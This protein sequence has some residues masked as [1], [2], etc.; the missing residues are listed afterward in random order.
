MCLCH[1]QVLLE[2]WQRIMILSANASIS[3][4]N[5]DLYLKYTKMIEEL[6]DEFLSEAGHTHEDIIN[7]CLTGVHANKLVW[8]F[9]ESRVHSNRRLQGSVGGQ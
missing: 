4:S 9:A 8:S 5:Y 6:L 7:L 1:L 3:C 2:V